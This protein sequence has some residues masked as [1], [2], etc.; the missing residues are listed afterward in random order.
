MAKTIDAINEAYEDLPKMKDS[1]IVHVRPHGKDS[2]DTVETPQG[3]KE[4][5]KCFWLNAKYIE[6]AIEN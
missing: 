4:M 6:K 5:K 1:S 2:S 3:T